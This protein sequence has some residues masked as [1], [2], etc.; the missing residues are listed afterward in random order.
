MKEQEQEYISDVYHMEQTHESL[1]QF[2][3]TH[4][5]NSSRSMQVQVIYS[6]IIMVSEQEAKGLIFVCDS[7]KY[8]CEKLFVELCC[9]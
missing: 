4:L 2:I 3:Q 7:C 5:H 8:F 1:Q 6:P 9:R